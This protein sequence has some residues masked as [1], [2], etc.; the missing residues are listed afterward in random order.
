M[1]ADW[2]AYAVAQKRAFTPGNFPVS[3]SIDARDVYRKDQ[4]HTSSIHSP[5]TVPTDWDRDDTDAAQNRAYAYRDARQFPLVAGSVVIP[6]FSLGYS[7]SDR[8]DTVD[9]VGISLQVN[10]GA[11]KTESPNYPTVVGVSYSF[12][13]DRQTTTL[14]LSDHRAAAELPH[15]KNA[16]TAS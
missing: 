9:G 11:A 14:E 12:A 13:G 3:R 7:V 10:A 5:G 15:A 1:E 6:R 4:V 8:I 16:D 2:G